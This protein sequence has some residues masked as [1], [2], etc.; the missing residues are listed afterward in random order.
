MQAPDKRFKAVLDFAR[1]DDRILAVGMEGSRVNVRIPPDEFQDY[2]IT[3]FVRSISAFTGDDGWLA[4][5]G[6]PLLIQKPEDMELY[7]AEEP[8]Y[9]YLM[10]FDDYGKLDLTLLEP[11]DLPAYLAQD[12]LRTI[13]LDKCGLVGSLPTPIIGFGSRPRVRLMIAA[14]SSGLSPF[15]LQ[16]DCAAVNSCMQ[17]IICTCCGVSCCGCWAGRLALRTDL[18]FLLGKIINSLTITFTRTSGKPCSRPTSRAR[19]KRFGRR[20]TAAWHCLPTPRSAAAKP[21]AARIRGMKRTSGGTSRICVANM[22][23]KHRTAMHISKDQS[24]HFG[25]CRKS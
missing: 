21:S 7:P 2:D 22:R 6:K 12:R 13:L 23:R 8:G 25:F 16:K 20:W 14:T 15:T 18:R 9:S 5:F 24:I 3:Y 1:A 11:A 17:P 19:P 4:R 10:L